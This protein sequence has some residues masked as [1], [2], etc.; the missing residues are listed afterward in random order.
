MQFRFQ[1]DQELILMGSVEHSSGEDTDVSDSETEEYAEKAYGELKNGK[2][3]VKLSDQSYS[4]PY[5]H[6]KKRKDFQYKELL[7]HA[8][9][10]GTVSSQK[11][12]ARDKANHLALAKYLESDIASVGGPS[13]PSDEVDALADQDRDEMFV[14]PWI[15]I[16]VNIPT[17]FK[18]GRCVG[19]SGSKLR[20]EL[21]AKGFNPTRVRPLWNYQGHSGTAIV[22]FRKDWSGF[23]NAMSFEKNYEA[24]HH[25]KKNWLVKN[26]KKSDLYA[27]VA[28]ADDYNSNNIV[29]ENLRKIGDIRTISDIMEEEA[30]KTTKLVGNLTNVIEAK[31]MHLLEMESKY[32]ETESSLSQLIKEKD[33]LHQEY[34]EGLSCTKFVIFQIK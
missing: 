28:R 12:T 20:D 25:G 31:K 4:C 17:S 15:G 5:C 19:A 26:E 13:K 34:N 16:V 32:K 11:R 2:H 30:R 22:E 33:N 1:W 3:Q 18:D 24:K 9:S 10:I 8:T 29:G 6:T 21:A 14:W 23:T 7:Q 27:W